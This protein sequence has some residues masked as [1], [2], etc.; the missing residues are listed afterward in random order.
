[1]KWIE[2][3]EWHSLSGPQLGCCNGLTT[4]TMIVF[5]S[6]SR[7][8][9]HFLERSEILLCLVRTIFFSSRRWKCKDWSYSEWTLSSLRR[10][11][12]WET[13]HLGRARIWWPFQP[14]QRGSLYLVLLFWNLMDLPNL[15]EESMGLI[16][17]PTFLMKLCYENSSNWKNNS[18]S[19]CL[20]R[21]ISWKVGN[22]CPTCVALLVMAISS[23]NQEELSL[24]YGLDLWRY[25]WIR[26]SVL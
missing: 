6:N 20:A 21:A 15:V 25:G 12:L 7:K 9:W 14:C 16:I 11:F 18:S 24:W 4:G 13:L 23:G 1:M 5:R 3:N 19:R 8:L 22:W 2:I 10:D 17:L 26:R